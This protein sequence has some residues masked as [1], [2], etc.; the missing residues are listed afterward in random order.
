MTNIE[1]ELTDHYIKCREARDLALQQMQYGESAS[2]AASLLT[3]T[4]SALK[5]LAKLQIDLYDAERV[6]TLQRVMTETLRH[7]SDAEYLLGV[8]ERLGKE[9]GL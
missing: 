8:F 2:A 9:V 5:E 7:A 4:T 1:K 3:A 6:K